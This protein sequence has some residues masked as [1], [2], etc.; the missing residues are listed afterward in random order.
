MPKIYSYLHCAGAL[1]CTYQTLFNT[2]LHPQKEKNPFGSDLIPMTGSA[3]EPENQPVPAS[4]AP[5]HK[6]KQWM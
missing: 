4:I 1:A 5:D 6:K 3:V 2:I